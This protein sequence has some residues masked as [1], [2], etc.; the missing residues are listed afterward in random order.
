MAQHP[1]KDRAW[2]SKAMEKQFVELKPE[3]D[4]ATGKDCVVLGLQATCI[5]SGKNREVRDEIR[6]LALDTNGEP[7]DVVFEFIESDAVMAKVF[8]AS[9]GLV[10]TFEDAGW[11]WG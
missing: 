8:N 10:R 3:T 2:R 5:E 4:E 7:L 11:S 1:G 6:R 9:E